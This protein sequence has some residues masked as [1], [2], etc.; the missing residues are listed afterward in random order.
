MPFGKYKNY[1]IK[2]I[3]PNYLIWLL[4]NS[5]SI[6]FHLKNYITEHLNS[7]TADLN[8]L[9]L[10]KRLY[11]KMSKKYHPDNGGNNEAMKAINDFYNELINIKND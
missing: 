4:E 10:I 9:K 8:D 3:D 7:I 1:L 2:D 5:E 11:Y 6:N